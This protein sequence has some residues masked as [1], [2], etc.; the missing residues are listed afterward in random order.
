ML[1]IHVRPCTCGISS[2][3][4]NNCSIWFYYLTLSWE[5]RTDQSINSM[6][7]L[8]IPDSPV[9]TIGGS[10]LLPT[11]LKKLS[12]THRHQFCIMF[13]NLWHEMGDYSSKI[14]E[15]VMKWGGLQV[16]ISQSSV[17]DLNDDS[18]LWQMEALYTKISPVLVCQTAP[19]RETGYSETTQQWTVTL[20]KLQ[21]KTIS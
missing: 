18:S 7:M 1:L 19:V 21:Y 16:A 13:N 14:G 15:A 11:A 4:L 3:K 5:S 8:T 10:A 12:Q 2:K 17:H 9:L 6:K 20:I